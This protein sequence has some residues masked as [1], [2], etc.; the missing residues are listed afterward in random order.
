MC[1]THESRGN[2]RDLNSSSTEMKNDYIPIRPLHKGLSFIFENHLDSLY[3]P[4]R[5]KKQLESGVSCV[6]MR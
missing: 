2:V 4:G 5:I 3:K 6:F 1:E